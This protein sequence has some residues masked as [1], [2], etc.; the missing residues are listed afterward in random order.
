MIDRY[1]AKQIV[2]Q[3]EIAEGLQKYQ[4]IMDK[5]RR[6]DV[7]HNKYFQEVFCKL[8]EMK[9]YY[10]VGDFA[11]KYFEAMEQMKRKKHI[12]F[13]D[14]FEKLTTIGN[15]KELTFSSRLLH[16]L[17]PQYPIWDKIVAED[18]FRMKRPIAGKAPAENYTKRYGE[19]VDRYYDYMK[20]EEGI[21]LIRL[22]D[23]RFPKEK[24]SDVK[25]LDFILRLDKQ[26]D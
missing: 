22:F 4:I 9:M 25:K 14:C 26:N 1:T 11:D 6:T 10:S 17:D 7:S 21:Y 23:E 16:T 2:E 20:S 3:R 15:R 18:H 24:I 13:K 8:Y 19:Y 5:L 12:S